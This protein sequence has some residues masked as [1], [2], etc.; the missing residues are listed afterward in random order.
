[1]SETTFSPNGHKRAVLY[2]R[3]SSDDRRKDGRNLK[4]QIDM[5]REYCQHHGYTVVAELAE[6]DRGADSANRDLPQLTKAMDMARG[7]EYQ[8]FVV[9]ELD[10]LARSLA[11]QMLVEEELKRAGVEIEYICGEYPDTPEGNLQKN[12]KAS[13]AEY[14][15]LKITE[16]N[17]RGRRNVVKGGRIMLHG[18]RPPYGYRATRTQRD[19]GKTIITGIVAHEPEA[20]IVRSIFQWYTADDSG[21]RLSAY[22]IAQKLSDMQVPTWSD[23]HGIIKKQIGVGRWSS[24]IVLDIIHSE[25]Y[26]GQWHYGRRNGKHSKMNPR[27][28]WLTLEVP[29]IVSPAQW[30]AAQDYCKDNTATSKR[31]VVNQYL[32]RYRAA[33]VCGYAARSYA[34]YQNGKIYLYYRCVS[35]SGQVRVR[36]NCGALTFRADL[37]DAAI[38]EWLKSWLQDPNTLGK[39]LEAYRAEREQANA[40]L[41][42]QLKGCNDLITNNLTQLDRLLDLYQLGNFDRDTLVAR[43]SRLDQAIASLKQERTKLEARLT[44]ELSQDD[45]TEIVTFAYELAAGLA[46][47][48]KDFEKR[49]RIIEVLDVRAILSVENGERVIS[50]SFVLSAP[51]QSRLPLSDYATHFSKCMAQPDNRMTITGRIVLH[52]PRQRNPQA[53]IVGGFFAQVGAAIDTPSKVLDPQ[54]AA[55]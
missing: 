21:E 23:V 3:V 8:V 10:R 55:L 29:A 1:M 48:D 11:K 12:V 14:E 31:H 9:R 6:D 18:D 5:G 39:K 24:T 20:A 27:E 53:D 40:P 35:V 30:Q 49:R 13:V 4:S 46:A 44:G 28:H 50:P 25:T 38:W 26:K 17:E 33:C 22:K 43:K 7:G 32:M 47:A 45:I 15:R 19:D 51:G 37:V 2:A 16:R 36:G 34:Q 52:D 42:A 41:I 54:P